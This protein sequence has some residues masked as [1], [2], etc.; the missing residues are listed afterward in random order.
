ME[1]WLRKERDE[2]RKRKKERKAQSLQKN[3][4]R[5]DGSRVTGDPAS[6]AVRILN[7][8]WAGGRLNSTIA[9]AENFVFSSN[10]VLRQ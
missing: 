7:N 6:S 5:V 3:D 8:G 4:K 2:D 10:S 1:S 9:G